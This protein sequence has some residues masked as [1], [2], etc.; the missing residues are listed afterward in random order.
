MKKIISLLISLEVF[1]VAVCFADKSSDALLHFN[2][3]TAFLNNEKWYEAGE[4]FQQAL[5]ANPS[6]GDAWYGLARASYEIND[7]NLCLSYLESAEKFARD[8]TDILN[9]RG[10][11]YISLKRIDEARI[12]FEDII[13]TYPNNIEARFGLAELELYTGGF[14]S[15]QLLYIDALKRNSTNR[16]ALL[17]LAVLAAETG[18][19]D[20]SQ[21]YIEQA[22]K[23]HAK[24]PEV[25]YLASYLSAKKGDLKDAERRARSAVQIQGDYTK[26]YVLLAQI[27]YA[28][29]KYDEVIDVCDYLLSQDKNT[30]SAWYLK[31][32][33]QYRQNKL[34]DAVESWE[35]ALD[36][37]GTDE[38][39]R[40]SLELVL[41]NKLPISD[42][43]RNQWAMYHVLKAR[44]YAK[45]FKGEEARYEYQ[46]ALKIAPGNFE[47]RSEFAELIRKA[48]L[49]ELYLDQLNF[50]KAN[51]PQDILGLSEDEKRK[52]TK[53]NDTIE[54]YS[55]LLKYSL[56][57]KW[58]VDPFYLDKTRWNL[59]VYY[60]KVP[61][62]L[63][64][65]DAEEIAAGMTRESFGG[66]S[67][68]S[69][70]VDRKPVSGYGEAYSLARK[71]KQ[72]YFILMKFEETEREVS[73]DAVIY[74]GRN[75][76]ETAKFSLFRTGNDRFVSV[77]RS[78]R[79]NVLNI[80]PARGKILARSGNEILVD[81]GK[82]EGLVKGAVLDVVKA[83]NIRTVDSGP[84]V[85]FEEKFGLGQIVIEEVGEEVSQGTLTQKSFYDR[86]NTGD[87]LLIKSLP[88]ENAEDNIADTNPAA[89][90]NGNPLNSSGRTEKLTASDLGLVKTPVF[91]DLIRNIY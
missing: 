6:F 91:L 35:T 11:C 70:A 75:G 82:S 54:A 9:L 56:N 33:S 87:E 30:I 1:A 79:R 25:H 84:G 52:Y 86:V 16:K 7:F 8:R 12:I 29:K 43:R 46:R 73:L 41:L 62:Q 20:V 65:A 88:S 81:M 17:S 83:G 19:D 32:Y 23:F 15:A 10:M 78:F 39:L 45:V 60:T 55:S 59:G 13:K 38:I 26:A 68:T 89:D 51:S 34:D 18:K 24:D 61:V 48:G 80:L 77:L 50:I 57:N 27:L 76:T 72:D 74:N 71:N 42:P 64:H 90:Q 67:I 49:N 3:G 14:D 85:I 22:M 47:A 58:D 44:E 36:I 5:Q 37:D 69:V 28:Q 63:I 53:L 2:K 31:G 4:E 66:T 21:K 40:S